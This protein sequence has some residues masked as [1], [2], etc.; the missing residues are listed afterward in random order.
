M[1]TPCS[2]ILASGKEQL[3]YPQTE[4][5]AK[6]ELVVRTPS[7]LKSASFFLFWESWTMLHQGTPA[8]A[9]GQHSQVGLLSIL[10]VPVHRFLTS[11]AIANILPSVQ[12]RVI[13]STGTSEARQKNRDIQ[14]SLRDPW[15]SCWPD[16]LFPEPADSP[17]G[18]THGSVSKLHPLFPDY[19][20]NTENHDTWNS[21]T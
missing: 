1:C 19:T 20:P 6:C 8:A 11:F 3:K 13:L 2:Y 12:R 18:R 14:K 15:A 7:C 5:S 9:E 17:R 16:S 10:I 4:G 21:E